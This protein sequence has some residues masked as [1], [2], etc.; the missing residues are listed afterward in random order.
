MT[1]PARLAW[2]VEALHGLEPGEDVL[3]DAGLDVMHARRAVG[4]RRPLVKGPQRPR[5]RLLQGAL[6][7]LAVLPPPEHLVLHR[8]QVD[9]RG[10]RGKA[11]PV[12]RLRHGRVAS[13]GAYA[14]PEGRRPPAAAPRYHPPWP[15][16]PRGS[17][18]TP[19][20]FC[21]RFYWAP[22]SPAGRYG[23][24]SSGG[25]GVI[26]S[27]GQAPGLTPSPGRCGPLAAAAVPI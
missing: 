18:P 21:C 7:H 20:G 16:P 12:V 11:G 10:Q 8:G 17:R 25:S 13:C 15:C 22:Y 23:H 27:T 19:L 4:G 26:W 1:V 2:H 24:R 9:R 5:G 6:E 3:E 14:S